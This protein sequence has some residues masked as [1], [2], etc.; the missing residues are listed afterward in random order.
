MEWEELHTGFFFKQCNPQVYLYSD[1]PT[2]GTHAMEDCNIVN[3][4][5]YS[6]TLHFEMV[7]MGWKV[8]AGIKKSLQSAVCIYQL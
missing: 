1:V 4:F 7:D 5:L 6:T 3:L 2:Y 8:C